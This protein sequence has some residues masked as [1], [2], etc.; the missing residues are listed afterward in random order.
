MKDNILSQLD[1]IELFDTPWSYGIC[2]NFMDKDVFDEIIYIC[3]LNNAIT[4]NKTGIRAD[5]KAH[6]SINLYGYGEKG[7]GPDYE[8]SQYGDAHLIRDYIDAWNET[9][10]ISS[11]LDFLSLCP[12]QMADKYKVKSVKQLK[13]IFVIRS[14]T[15]SFNS[16]VHTDVSKKLISITVYLHPLSLGEN[17]LVQPLG[18]NIY[19]SNIIM[20]AHHNRSGYMSEGDN[21]N[22]WYEDDKD[23]YDYVGSIEWQS[24]RSIIFSQTQMGT[25]HSFNNYISCSYRRVALNISI[26]PK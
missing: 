24:N 13:T 23:S 26:V 5:E 20:P 8:D 2:D 18:T 6:R 25:L 22:R 17:H 15:P 7:S 16:K 9:D 14:V 12:T 10:I 11:Y 1:K 21:K 3:K 4:D 19:K